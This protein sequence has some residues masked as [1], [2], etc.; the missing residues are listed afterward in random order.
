MPGRKKNWTNTL[1]IR[2]IL[3]T[4][5]KSITEKKGLKIRSLNYLHL[6][7]KLQLGSLKNGF[8]KMKRVY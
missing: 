4:Y 6:M 2:N 5:Y 8:M 1:K 7:E 3:I